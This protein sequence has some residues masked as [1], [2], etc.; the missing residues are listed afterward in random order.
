MA[1]ALEVPDH[2]RDCVAIRARRA[3]PD[4]EGVWM[5]GVA[6]DGA[7]GGEVVLVVT[8]QKRPPGGG[9]ALPGVA[10]GREVSAAS[11]FV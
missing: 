5:G 6:G 1:G 8:L 3:A 2:V 9:R 4:L 11:V 10:A 7:R